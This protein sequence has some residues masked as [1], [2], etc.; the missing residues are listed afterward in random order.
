MRITRGHIIERL[1]DNERFMVLC[2]SPNK[3]ESGQPYNELDTVIDYRAHME[4]G[5]GRPFGSV[6]HTLVDNG[7]DFVI[8]DN[9][10]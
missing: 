2:A 7:E 6:H 4:D 5:N 8:I 9:W 10:L 3:D 1:V